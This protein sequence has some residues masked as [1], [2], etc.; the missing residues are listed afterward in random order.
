MLLEV[1]MNLF[2]LREQKINE[3]KNLDE[4]I[5]SDLDLQLLMLDTDD[6][7]NNGDYRDKVWF[8]VYRNIAR[9]EIDDYKISGSLN[10]N[11][12]ELELLNICET[13]DETKEVFNDYYRINENSKSVIGIKLEK[14]DID[15][16][17]KIVTN[18]KPTEEEND[19]YRE[20]LLSVYSKYNSSSDNVVHF[21]F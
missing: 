3:I 7:T 9:R 1:Y 17:L 6:R 4:V 14:K 12:N 5:L 2:E 13:P 19:V 15:N 20:E 16:L 10:L 21:K 18:Y 8:D 11:N